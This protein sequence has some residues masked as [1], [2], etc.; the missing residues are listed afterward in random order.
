MKTSKFALLLTTITF[1]GLAMSACNNEAITSK[2]TVK[3][4][5]IAHKLNRV[6][7]ALSDAITTKDFRLYGLSGRRIV[8][9]GLENKNV[10]EIK[11]RCG[12]RL[13]SG[14]GDVLK[15]SQDRENR[16][17]NYQF[18]VKINEKLY[19]LCLKK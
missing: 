6:E 16:R 3:E 4:E 15:N 9:P 17:L 10:E 7:Q 1:F 11:K 5:P 2:T 18:A 14:T 13:L 19:A 8:L 12:I